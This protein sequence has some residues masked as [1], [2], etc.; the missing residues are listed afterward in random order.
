M[1]FSAAADLTS[2][3]YLFEFVTK[4]PKFMQSDE[5]VGCGLCAREYCSVFRDLD[6]DG[7]CFE[8]VSRRAGVNKREE[9]TDIV[10]VGHDINRADIE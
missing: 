2:S 8:S 9:F 1:M 5:L 10:S 4:A 3:V 6:V 7:E